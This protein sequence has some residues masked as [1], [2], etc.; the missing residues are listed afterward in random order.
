M[1]TNVDMGK[2]LDLLF[3]TGTSGPKRKP[4]DEKNDK[5]TDSSSD[6]KQL[7][8]TTGAQKPVVVEYGV[9]NMSDT[10]KRQCDIVVVH[11]RSYGL[12]KMQPTPNSNSQPDEEKVE[13]ASAML[14]KTGIF[15]KLTC[16]QKC[17]LAWTKW[18]SVF[19]S[20]SDRKLLFGIMDKEVLSNPELMT[21]SIRKSFELHQRSHADKFPGVATVLRE[22]QKRCMLISFPTQVENVEKI[23]KRCF[24]IYNSSLVAYVKRINAQTLLLNN[25]SKINLP[26][27]PLY[28]ELESKKKEWTTYATQPIRE[29][30][31]YSVLQKQSGRICDAWE[32][33]ADYLTS[34]GT[35]MD[36]NM[37]YG[38]GYHLE[39]E[40]DELDEDNTTDATNSLFACVRAK[41]PPV[42]VN[43]RP[44]P[45]VVQ[46]NIFSQ[47]QQ[48]DIDEWED[49]HNGDH[50][51]NKHLDDYE[52]LVQQSQNL[53]ADEFERSRRAAQEQND[54]ETYL[55]NLFEEDLKEFEQLKAS[56][57]QSKQNL[58][59]AH[60]EQQ[61]H[62]FTEAKERE[63]K[64]PLP[65]TETWYR[66]QNAQRPELS[67]NDAPVVVPEP[68]EQD[69][70]V[71]V[72]ASPEEKKEIEEE[73][74][75]VNAAQRQLLQGLGGYQLQL[76][77]TKDQLALIDKRD[78][79]FEQELAK[80][81]TDGARLT[82]E[83]KRLDNEVKAAEKLSTELAEEIK[84]VA[85]S[86]KKMGTKFARERDLDDLV[87]AFKASKLSLE[88]KYAELN[89]LTE[90]I[91]SGIRDYA[92]YKIDQRT[93]NDRRRKMNTQKLAIDQFMF[94]ETQKF[95]NAKD[96][97]DRKVKAIRA[98][99]DERR[100]KNEDSAFEAR[101]QKALGTA[102]NREQKNEEAEKKA[103]EA[104]ELDRTKQA[105]SDKR[106][107]KL[108]DD[109]T[110]YR[111]GSVSTSAN[112]P[113][114]TLNSFINR[115]GNV[116]GNIDYL[117]PPPPNPAAQPAPRR[118]YLHVNSSLD[119]EDNTIDA[120]IAR[121]TARRQV[122]YSVPPAP[123]PPNSDNRMDQDQ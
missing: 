75:S 51:D 5:A 123:P 23:C 66:M 3:A 109:I 50:E 84:Q 119:D 33:M 110:K 99:A 117:R 55:G 45:A 111:N 34:T 95:Q 19:M 29:D 62:V 57:N 20:E 28:Y 69:A 63:R 85:N 113:P 61:Q 46:Q 25:L 53:Y 72:G 80:F 114:A 15:I 76:Q 83:K 98:A 81:S 121:E 96:E 11:G 73:N 42:Y 40:W 60:Q 35:D 82:E 12:I 93:N 4:A 9:D 22:W 118:S 18:T 38:I 86:S 43:K 14:E 8:P 49:N 104:Q 100:R 106:Y 21:P 37:K 10:Q 2:F 13:L 68:L 17:I 48:P 107:Q 44:K 97:R 102:L 116:F 36:S 27:N 26:N 122:M 7:V 71:F 91:N 70:G 52:D 39:L 101:L 74:N 16:F 120:V 47:G 88:K 59:H 30:M 31:K 77:Q 65:G 24:D 94:R 41:D 112:L 78:R 6:S 115:T 54:D 87:N 108:T 64:E 32:K 103:R 105:T 56:G 1:I 79:E 58:E 92:T 90:K 67:Q 89:R